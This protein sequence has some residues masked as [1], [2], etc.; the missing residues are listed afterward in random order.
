MFENG[1]DQVVGERRADLPSATWISS[2]SARPSL[3][4][5]A[6]DLALDGGAG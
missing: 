5:N 6:L 1:R 4:V 3:R 2:I